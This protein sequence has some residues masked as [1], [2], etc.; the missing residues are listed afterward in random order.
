MNPL[1]IS[2]TRRRFLRWTGLVGGLAISGCAR[3]PAGPPARLKLLQTRLPFAPAQAALAAEQAAAAKE[4]GVGLDLEAQD[5]ET[6]RSSLSRVAAAGQLPDLL[7]IGTADFGVLSA[8]GLLADVRAALDRVA[9]LDGD[10]FPPLGAVAIGDALSAPSSASISSTPSATPSA[11]NSSSSAPLPATG[12]PLLSIGW[13]WLARQDLLAQKNV[14]PPKTFDDW[15]AAATRLADPSAGVAGFGA[16]LPLGDDTTRLAQLGFLA[17]GAPLFGDEG[18]HV[19]FDPTVGATALG[20]LASLFASSG[21]PALAPPGVADWTVGALETAFAR[22]QVAQMVDL[23]GSYGRLVQADPSLADRIAV[24][25]PPAGPKGWNT[26]AEVLFYAVPRRAAVDAALGLVER[27]L[28]PARLERVASSGAG[29]VVPPYAYLTKVPFW[30]AD[31]NYRA[32]FAN[33][34]GDPSHSLSYANPGAPGPFS[35]PVALAWQQQILA[36]AL[37]SVVLGKQ[38]PPAAAALLRAQAAALVP[39]ALDQ[40]PRPTPTPEPGWLRWMR[41]L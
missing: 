8:K 40:E 22:G 4:S 31:P 15:R 23:G 25:P 19:D 2:V 24:L 20:T 26:A 11:S 16:R 6:I 30:D 13:G 21:G 28:Q 41:G 3:A 32:L 5:G 36:A 1:V 35:G 10:L 18:L 34:R 9:G 27:I 38:T 17:Y 7:S 39:A 12:L 37:R 33:A 29:S 14:A